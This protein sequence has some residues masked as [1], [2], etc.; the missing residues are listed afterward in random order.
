ML[1]MFLKKYELEVEELL[2]VC[3]DSCPFM[4]GNNVDFISLVRKHLE[5]SICCHATVLFA[6]VT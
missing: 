5:S 2:L 1:K 3:N 4:T 6:K